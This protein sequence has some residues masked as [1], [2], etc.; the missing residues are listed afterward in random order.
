LDDLTKMDQTLHTNTPVLAETQFDPGELPAD[1]RVVI[2]GGGIAGC[3]VA[4][5]LA[6]LGWGDVILLES[7]KVASG[8]TWHSAGQVGQL[9]ASSSQTKINK[10]SAELYAELGESAGWLQCGGL[11]LATSDE[12]WTQLRRNA[13]MAEV[14]GVEAELIDAAEISSRWPVIETSDV[15]GGIWLPGD[16]RVL[17]G[18]CAVELATRSGVPVFEDT[19]VEEILREGETIT[20]V[21]TSRGEIKADWVVLTGGMWSRQLGLGIGVD[22]PLYPCEHHYV[23]T[24]PVD[25]VTRDFPCSRDPD[26]GIYFRSLDDGGMKLGAFKLRSKAWQVGDRVPEDFHHDLLEPDWEDFAQPLASHRHR[27]PSTRDVEIVKFVNGPESFTPDNQFLMGEPTGT[28]GLFVLAGFNSA[29]IACAGGA[30]QYAAEWMANGG[31]TMDLLSVDIRRFGPRHNGTGFLQ[32][33]VTEVLGMHYSMAWPGLQM[34]T[35]RDLMRTPLY[36]THVANS[37]RFGEAGGVERPMWFGGPEP[38]YTFGKPVWL[39]TVAQEVSACRNGVAVFDQSTF[40]K[41]RTHDLEGLQWLCANDVD[42]EPG[43]A[44][45]TAML[46]GRGTFESD[47]TVIREAVDSF[48]LVSSSASRYRDFDWIRNNGKCSDLCDV[49][50]ELGVLGVMGPRSRELLGAMVDGMAFGGARRIDVAGQEVLA[51]R[52]TYVGELGWELHMAASAMQPVYDFIKGGG[53]TD[54][55][56]H[57]INSMRIEKGY[58]AFGHELSPDETPVEAGLGFA[59]AWDS[60]FLGRDALLKRERTK[61]MVSLV[62][63]DPRVMLWGGEPITLGGEV[64]GHTTSATYGPTLGASVALGYVKQFVKGADYAILNAGESCQAR[65]TLSSPFDPRRERILC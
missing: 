30:G 7:G 65:V 44:V 53:A 15:V 41:F 62:L 24:A 39:E 20:G 27:L 54:A 9:R 61:R 52:I 37:A 59:L 11:Q 25:G 19:A 18:A 10:A 2:V 33:R 28:R 50:E 40:S 47:L 29:G 34:E 1:A 64:V 55:G 5:H 42:V 12:R 21:R 57:A 38:A 46:N 3:S 6:K 56:H 22:I 31:M 60:D 35:A 36:E 43:R 32:E 14:F 8:T 13:A 4:Y 17:P 51:V 23:I 58:R 16:G 48:Y 63:A 45:Y 49:T 26:A